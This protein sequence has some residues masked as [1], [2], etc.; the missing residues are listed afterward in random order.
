[1]EQVYKKD[2]LFLK[3]IFSLFISMFVIMTLVGSKVFAS[4]ALEG[5]YFNGDSFSFEALPDLPEGCDSYLLCDISYNNDNFFIYAWD[6]S[7]TYISQRQSNGLISFHKKGTSESSTGYRTSHT[8]W[9][10]WSTWA[11]WSSLSNVN[12][13][14]YTSK[15]YTNKALY[16]YDNVSTL[17]DSDDNILFQAPPQQVEAT[18]ILTPIVQ[19]QEMKPLQEILQILPI[20]MIVVVSYL[21]LRK[22]LRMLFNFLRQS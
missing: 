15:C 10:N 19:G 9:N 12:S 22:G 14:G 20:V 21:A 11:K 18:T 16:N 6:S 1:M 3:I 5:E 13:H 17:K 2:G 7:T 8:S 4:W